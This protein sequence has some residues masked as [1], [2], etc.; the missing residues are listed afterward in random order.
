MTTPPLDTPIVG[1]PL[2]VLTIHRGQ[3]IAVSVIGIVLGVIGLVVPGATLFTVAIVFGIY[4]VAS[5]IF[6]LTAALVAHSMSV[7]LRWLSGILGLLVVIAGVICLANPFGVLPVLALLIGIGWIA[8]GI[9]DFMAGVQGTV[10]PRWLAWV[11]GAV[12]IIAG[13]VTFVLPALVVLS[14]FVQI[15]AIMLIVVSITTLLT[16]PRKPKA[17]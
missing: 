15:A 8:E 1:S 4:L 5:G 14:V 12:S 16:L 9:V 2:G 3:L 6:R 10:K 11:S 13:V 17:A 7:G